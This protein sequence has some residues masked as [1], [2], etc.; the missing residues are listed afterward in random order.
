MLAGC[1]PRKSPSRYST[2]CR[3]SGILIWIGLMANALSTV[4]NLGS[5][6]SQ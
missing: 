4:F 2:V 5:M 3:A 6:G 1:F